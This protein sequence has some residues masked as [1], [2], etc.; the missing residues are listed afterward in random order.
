MEEFKTKKLKKSS[1]SKKLAD[2]LASRMGNVEMK[3]SKMS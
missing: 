1:S 3:L 2:A